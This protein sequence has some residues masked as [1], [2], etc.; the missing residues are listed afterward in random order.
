MKTNQKHN[1]IAVVSFNVFVLTYSMFNE[2]METLNKRLSCAVHG[3]DS[4]HQGPP[5][6][7]HC[8]PGPGRSCS[9]I[10]VKLYYSPGPC[11]LLDIQTNNEENLQIC[12]LS[13]DFFCFLCIPDK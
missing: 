1:I 9:Q 11:S 13:S 8:S 10:N 3:K 2:K 5:L 7:S 6:S 4:T 12:K